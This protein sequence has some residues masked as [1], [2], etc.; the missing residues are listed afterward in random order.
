MKT[1]SRNVRPKRNAAEGEAPPPAAV[2]RKR[3][4]RA[5]AAHDSGLPLGDPSDEENLEF[6][7]AIDLFK[8][9]T[10]RNFPT[11]TEVLQIVQGLGYAKK[12]ASGA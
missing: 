5:L 7:K 4:A 6:L 2:P 1:T 3:G 9:R 10:G 8:R 11:W 12:P